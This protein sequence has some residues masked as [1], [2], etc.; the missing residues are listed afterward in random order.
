MR[1][2]SPRLLR[3]IAPACTPITSTLRHPRTNRLVCLFLAFAAAAAD[4]DDDE[5]EDEDS[6]DLDLNASKC[7]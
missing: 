4:E 5:D 1:L 3:I 7:T 2:T 6:L